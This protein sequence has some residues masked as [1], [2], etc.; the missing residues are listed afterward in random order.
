[1]WRG[2]YQRLSTSSLAVTSDQL[3]RRQSE[4]RSCL[5]HPVDLRRLLYR[6]HTGRGG[7]DQL[8][9]SNWSLDRLRCGI[10]HAVLATFASRAPLCT[11]HDVLNDV[12]VEHLVYMFDTV[13]GEMRALITG[14]L[15]SAETISADILPHSESGCSTEPTSMISCN[16]ASERRYTVRHCWPQPLA[17]WHRLYCDAKLSGNSW[18]RCDATGT[19][20]AQCYL[21]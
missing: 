11:R 17:V 14:D 7:V 15:H 8:S 18:R 6:N 20:A 19:K 9:N 10:R 13:M 5:V 3:S 12:C 21:R 1:M 2:N 16:V 4:C